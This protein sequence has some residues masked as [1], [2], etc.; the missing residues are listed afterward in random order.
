MSCLDGLALGRRRRR[1]R[2]R[3]SSRRLCGRKLRLRLGLVR[4]RVA[5]NG[6]LELAHPVPERLPDLREPLAAEEQ[7]RDQG[8]KD[9]V[10]GSLEIPHVQR[11]AR[12]SSTRARTERVSL[13]WFALVGAG[14]KPRYFRGKRRTEWHCSSWR[15]CTSPS[16][17]APR[18][19]RASISR[20]TRTRCTRS[21]GRTAPG[22]RPSPTPSWVTRRTRSPRGVSSSTVRT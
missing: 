20:W 17:T 2:R 6:V 14:R 7:Q 13:D 4:G 19:S 12:F 21:W 10:P 9:D 18:S 1:R 3:R 11:V 15:T 5:G 8:E 16:R 22:S